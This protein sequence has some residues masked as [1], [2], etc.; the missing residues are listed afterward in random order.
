MKF[1]HEILHEI[2]AKE[3]SFAMGIIE[4]NFQNKFS[5]SSSFMKTQNKFQI[6]HSL[7]LK[8]N[9]SLWTQKLHHLFWK[10]PNSPLLQVVWVGAAKR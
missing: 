6:N 2:L 5:I 4:I 3:F 8:F 7:I 9:V 1:W 10:A